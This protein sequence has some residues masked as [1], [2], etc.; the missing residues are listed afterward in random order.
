[1]RAW[2]GPRRRRRPIVE[3]VS[4]RC[5]RPS[6]AGPPVPIRASVTPESWHPLLAGT[7]SP[8][9]ETASPQSGV[10]QIEL[11]VAVQLTPVA[12]RH[13]LLGQRLGEPRLTG[14]GTTTVTASSTGLTGG[15]TTVQ[16]TAGAF[17]PCSGTCD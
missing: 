15:T 4:P 13:A 17:V 16:A 10:G 6:L 12:P 11:P 8:I 3:S 14:Q 5:W 1:M 7:S 2:P 9:L